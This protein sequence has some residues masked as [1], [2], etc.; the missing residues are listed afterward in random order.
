MVPQSMPCSTSA[1]YFT[2]GRPGAAH[3]G[4]AA[5]DSERARTGPHPVVDRRG[6][7]VVVGDVRTGATVFVYVFC[8]LL[9]FDDAYVTGSTSPRNAPDGTGVG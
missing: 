3:L 4:G 9:G 7:L 6:G 5:R 1:W 8:R 2:S